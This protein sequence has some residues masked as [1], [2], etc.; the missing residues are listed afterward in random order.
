MET[1]QMP[2]SGLYRLYRIGKDD[3]PFFWS[4]EVQER[5]QRIR[6][7]P[8]HAAHLANRSGIP[9]QP[10]DGQYWNDTAHMAHRGGADWSTRSCM[11]ISGAAQRH[12]D[13]PRNFNVP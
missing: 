11:E 10:P 2:A 3:K 5:H 12:F 6:L 13:A 1:V 4:I 9:L 8:R 7:P